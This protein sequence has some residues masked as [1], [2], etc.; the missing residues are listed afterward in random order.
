[1]QEE[2]F[3]REYVYQQTASM[4]TVWRYDATIRYSTLTAFRAPKQT[5]G[6]MLGDHAFAPLK[7][8]RAFLRCGTSLSW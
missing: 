5:H 4:K 2:R 1:M 7:G 3:T 8:V 6:G